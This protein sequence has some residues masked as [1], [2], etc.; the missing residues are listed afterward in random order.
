MKGIKIVRQK[1]INFCKDLQLDEIGFV[2]CQGIDHFL[3]ETLNQEMITFKVKTIV[4]IAFPYCY[5][6]LNQLKNNG[7][8]IYAKRR[9][10]HYVVK[11]YLTQIAQY[12]ESLGGKTKIFVDSNALK[13]RY[14]ATLAG[15][16][17]IG[18]NQM[19]INP[20][21]GSY[22]F[23]GEVATDL[24]VETEPIKKNKLSCGNCRR[25]I[26]CC[27]GGALDFQ[28]YKVENCLSYLTQKKQLTETETQ[29]VQK[30]GLI[31]GCDSC[32]LCCPY[33][34]RARLSPLE[35]FQK[36]EVMEQEPEVYVA[37]TNAFFKNQ[38]KQSSCGWRGKKVIERNA[39]FKLKR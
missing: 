10:Y 30:S 15:I 7:F 17:F 11:H 31:F 9:D 19:L 23:L 39:Q 16:G 12:I 36:L 34:Q 6:P 2:S 37:M 5:E 27:P 25:C 20:K 38:I 26:T 24:E 3:H 4:S 33:N 18:R 8:S 29:K 14:L 21:Y 28:T 13:E 22:V 32:Q 35:A 1:I